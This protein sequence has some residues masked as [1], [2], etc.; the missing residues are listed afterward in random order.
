MREK[1]YETILYLLEEYMGEHIGQDMKDIIKQ[2]EI[3]SIYVNT[4]IDIVS[5]NLTTA[6]KKEVIQNL[7]YHNTELSQDDVAEIYKHLNINDSQ[8]GGGGEGF[9]VNSLSDLFTGDVLSTFIETKLN[10]I[11][12]ATMV[13]DDFKIPIGCDWIYFLLFVG[14]AVPFL[15]LGADIL[16]IIKALLERKFMLAIITTCTCF[17]SVL[18]NMHIIDLG[19][20]FK[21][22]FYLD[23]QSYQSEGT[24]TE[25]KGIVSMLPS[26]PMDLISKLTPTSE[27]IQRFNTLK[28]LLSNSS[29]TSV[30]PSPSSAL[31]GETSKE[32]RDITTISKNIKQLVRSK[33]EREARE[34]DKIIEPI[35]SESN[36]VAA[37]IESE[38]NAASHKYSNESEVVNGIRKRIEENRMGGDDL[39]NQIRRRIS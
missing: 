22:F 11:F 23:S 19:A 12:S 20:L 2:L 31:L 14:A 26:S 15:G 38:S 28:D 24:G 18:T 16:I 4:Y 10:E 21:M 5:S 1:K 29:S 39:L 7:G 27:N 37:P 36:A 32:S 25:S 34:T 33:I 6:E 13:S 17:A 3:L 30:G 8:R 35:E 9:C